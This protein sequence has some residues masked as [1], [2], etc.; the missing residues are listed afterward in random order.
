M[1]FRITSISLQCFTACVLLSG[2]AWP[3]AVTQ[4]PQLPRLLLA[5]VYQPGIRLADYWVSE[6]LD[7]VRAYWDGRHL[8]SREGNTYAAPA[9]FTA[10]FPATPL[11]GELWMGR[12]TFEE[13]SST[14]RRSRPDA[15]QWRRVRYMVFDLPAGRDP[16]DSRLARLQAL[17]RTAPSPY[18]EIVRQY[19]VADRSMLTQHLRAIVAQGGEG[20]ML[21]RG[22]SHYIAGRSDDLLK[23]KLHDDAEAVVVGYVPGHGKYRGMVGALIVQT[24]QGLQFR[25]GSGLSDAER[26]S[27]PPIGS[28]VTY[29]YFGTTERGIPRFA[30]FLR[31]RRP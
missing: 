27:P 18:I 13:L 19:R 30:S 16:F 23:L 6:K 14:V 11:D 22:D 29:R 31:L 25:L 12:G 1:S 3:V 9:W 5:E 10:G 7:G 21:H 15:A 4:S 20:L 8:I 2:H 17:L 24:P 28:T 26:A